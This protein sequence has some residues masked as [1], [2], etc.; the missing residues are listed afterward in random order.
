MTPEREEGAWGCPGGE[1]SALIAMSGGVDSS[2]A[3]WLMQQ[4]GCL[5]TGVTMRLYRNADLGLNPYH[6]CCSQQDID[7]AAD[8]A[9]QLDIPYEVLDFTPGFKK[10]VIE[11][12]IRVYRAGGTPNPC[13]DCNRYMKFDL[14]LAEA[15]RRGIDCV[16]TGHY[17]RI[18][19]DGDRRRYLLK[20]AADPDK[21][22]SY[23][24]YMLT[25]DQLARL[26]FPLG[27]MRKAE[28]RAIAGRLGLC[29]ARKHDSQDICF[30]PD[31]D[32]ARFIERY[33]GQPCAP[34]DFLD[35]N[36]TPVGRHRGGAG[37][38]AGAAERTGAGHG[39]AGLCLCQG[40]GGQY[41]DGGAGTGPLQSRAAGGGYELD[42]I[43]GAGW[44]HAGG[45]KGALP[46][47]G[48]GG[49]PCAAGGRPGAAGI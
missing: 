12:F 25:Q 2:V 11:K 35:Q 36:G 21:D 10:Q 29:N 4:R 19:Y 14:L 48:A 22:Q 38:Y 17:A 43:R 3:A 28:T 41:G 5:C 24:L 32:Y 9:F 20:K 40:H 23:V 31:G 45:G 39:P 27:G 7:D 15:A 26:R 47:A 33:T 8:V 34:G 18:V 13:I 16:A 42:H 44:A 30:V 46:A 37:L 1:K 6:T 49:D